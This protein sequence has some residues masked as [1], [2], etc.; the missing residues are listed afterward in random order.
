MIKFVPNADTLRS[1]LGLNT[2]EAITLAQQLVNREKTKEDLVNDGFNRDAFMDTDSLPTWFLDDEM[3]HFR[4][5]I[6]VTKDA[7][8]ALRAK[9]RAL[10]ARPI[11]KVR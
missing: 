7:V 1:G 2:A 5:N 4:R 11:K 3:R 8:D 9:S 6:P 10:D